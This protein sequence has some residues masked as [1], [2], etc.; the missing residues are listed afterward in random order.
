MAE[1]LF[2]GEHLGCRLKIVEFMHLG[3]TVNQELYLDLN[4]WLKEKEDIL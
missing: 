4:T 1:R 3:A 2:A